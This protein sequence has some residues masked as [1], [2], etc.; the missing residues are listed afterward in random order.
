MFVRS[1]FGD[2]WELVLA[3]LK[4]GARC[5]FDWVPSHTSEAAVLAAGGR[6]GDKAGNDAGDE[7]A[8]HRARQLR[9]PFALPARRAQQRAD[10]AAAMRLVARA[11]LRGVARRPQKAPVVPRPL[12]VRAKRQRVAAPPQ[13]ADLPLEA[14]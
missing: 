2:L 12:Q 4:D 6:P 5:V 3:Q 14:F 13:V 1:A 8:K 9:A 10:E 11:Q 7:A